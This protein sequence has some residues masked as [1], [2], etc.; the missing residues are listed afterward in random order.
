MKK[1]I[2]S[3]IIA[4]TTI[5]SSASEVYRFKMPNYKNIDI[6]EYQN[7][8]NTN[9]DDSDDGGS[10]GFGGGGGS[11]TPSNA[12]I[13]SFT[14]STNSYFENQTVRLNW[15]VSNPDTL[16][17][18]DDNILTN[19]IADVTGLSSYDVSPVGD[20]EYYL[21]AVSDVKSVNVY[22]YIEQNRTC[23]EWNPKEEEI[24]EGVEFNQTRDC[25]VEYSSLEPRNVTVS[26]QEERVQ[27][28]TM[29]ASL[30]YGEFSIPNNSENIFGEDEYSRVVI[31]GSAFVS[32]INRYNEYGASNNEVDTMMYSGE[33]IMYAE[34]PFTIS[35][36]GGGSSDSGSTV[37]SLYYEDD[38]SNWVL[39]SSCEISNRSKSCYNAG[40]GGMPTAPNLQKSKRW[41][42]ENTQKNQ[43]RFEIYTK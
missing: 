15:N 42:I 33:G 1:T 2:I 23:D 41:K 4:L 27:E 14:A 43:I 35:S 6:K 24:G 5:S 36:L 20:K 39:F 21:D 10:L 19:H 37:L 40:Y 17:I 3:A 16:N 9:D 22:Q 12:V 28:G 26:E 11:S 38:S 31:S 7:N 8:D 18:Y 34:K 25:I 13:N 32:Y 29:V 30:P